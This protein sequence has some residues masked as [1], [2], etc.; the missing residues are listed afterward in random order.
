[1]SAIITDLKDIPFYR[2]FIL[3]KSKLNNDN[4]QVK[5]DQFFA[6]ISPTLFTYLNHSQTE[7]STYESHLNE[8]EKMRMKK[9]LGRKFTVNEVCTVY[10][11]KYE[12][13]FIK[14]Y[15]TDSNNLLLDVI[16]VI[17]AF[18]MADELISP[19]VHFALMDQKLSTI[20]FE[21]E[22]Y[23][24][25]LWQYLNINKQLP[26]RTITL[27]FSQC[28]ELIR[29]ISTLRFLYLD[30]KMNNFVI[31]SSNNV[32]KIIDFDSDFSYHEQLFF[33]HEEKEKLHHIFQI[34]NSLSIDMKPIYFQIMIHLMSTF[35]THH[36]CKFSSSESL[37]MFSTKLTSEKEKNYHQL[38]QTSPQSVV[39]V[40]EIIEKSKNVHILM[41]AY[42]TN[43]AKTNDNN[44][45][46]SC[47]LMV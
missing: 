19:N 26:E 43:T 10:F 1:M 22:A 41:D 17:N 8:L 16:S 42:T 9:L 38:L 25:D 35:L 3:N 15:V 5:L 13:V 34:K 39:I 18:Y 37:Q 21:M 33:L 2:K 47:Q 36:L 4:L 14:E 7:E 29:D 6:S 28:V 45:G 12:Q 31:N 27:I 11:N 32:I 20:S 24:I 44:D 30:I 23:E 46:D 40:N